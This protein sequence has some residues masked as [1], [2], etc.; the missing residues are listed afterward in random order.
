MLFHLD[1]LTLPNSIIT[2]G[3]VAHVEQ[4]LFSDQDLFG[5]VEAIFPYTLNI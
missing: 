4:L 5:E 2:R 1:I 3:T